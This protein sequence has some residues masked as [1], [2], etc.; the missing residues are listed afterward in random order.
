M[1]NQLN[2]TVKVASDGGYFSPDIPVSAEGL[3]PL[4]Y[5]GT[6]SIKFMKGD[7]LLKTKTYTNSGMPNLFKFICN[8]LAGNY[9]PANAPCQ[10]KLYRLLSAEDSDTSEGIL[11][12]KFNWNTH[13]EELDAATPYILYDTTP[14][15]KA[16]NEDGN[17][18]YATSYHFRVPFTLI[19]EEII[20]AVGFYPSNVI[21][22]E[23]EVC[24]YYLFTT[25]EE[26][27]NGTEV[28]WDPIK[29]P[30]A[31][32]GNYSIIVEWTMAV[33]NKQKPQSKT[34][35]TDTNLTQGGTN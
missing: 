25:Q 20:H 1:K 19:S 2:K 30:S 33:M 7:S 26:S 31:A 28:V 8:A 35:Q 4:D 9:I 11:P 21:S 5:L 22:P 18:H 34:D 6:V 23:D 15:V 12:V 13:F 14:K 16:I 29:L 27:F 17:N 24:A 32:N 10:I 3:Q